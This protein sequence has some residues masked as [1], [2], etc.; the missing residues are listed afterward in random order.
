[1]ADAA[2]HLPGD[3]PYVVVVDARPGWRDP[4]HHVYG[5]RKHEA[6]AIRWAT[7]LRDRW[8]RFFLYPVP[9]FTWTVVDSR[10]G[11]TVFE[12]H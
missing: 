11:T 12:I 4:Y 2:R 7:T 3:L 6:T 5:C 10:D 9:W 1:M 8:H